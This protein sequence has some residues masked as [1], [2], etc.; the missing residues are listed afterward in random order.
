M[1][2]VKD[3]VDFDLVANHL[4]LSLVVVVYHFGLVVLVLVADWLVV[5]LVAA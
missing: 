3:R 1:P 2:R 4:A 5:V